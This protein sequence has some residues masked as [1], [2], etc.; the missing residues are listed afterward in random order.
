MTNQGQDYIMTAKEGGTQTEVLSYRH[1]TLTYTYRSNNDSLIDRANSLRVNSLL[2]YTFFI[3]YCTIETDGDNRGKQQAH[4]A[5]DSL[6]ATY[7]TDEK[8]HSS[9]DVTRA[10]LIP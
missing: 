6:Q 8:S 7:A 5:T 10:V 1:T 9:D 3:G 2:R 4:E